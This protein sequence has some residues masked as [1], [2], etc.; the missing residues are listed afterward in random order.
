MPALAV[1]TNARVNLMAGV[2][3]PMHRQMTNP[4]FIN[5]KSPDVFDSKA[6]IVKVAKTNNAGMDAR[7]MKSPDGPILKNGMNVNQTTAVMKNGSFL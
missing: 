2:I 7:I 3:A 6:F 1:K 4:A 5:F